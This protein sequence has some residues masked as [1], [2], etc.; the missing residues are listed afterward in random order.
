MRTLGDKGLWPQNVKQLYTLMLSRC[1]SASNHGLPILNW[2]ARACPEKVKAGAA[3]SD[4]ELEDWKDPDEHEHGKA[5]LQKAD[6]TLYTVMSLMTNPDSEGGRAK[7]LGVDTGTIAIGEG[8]K[9]LEKYYDLFKQDATSMENADDL[10]DQIA[11]FQSHK[12]ESAQ[13]L[14][15]RFNA[16][17]TKLELKSSTMKFPDEFLLSR[18]VRALPTTG[19]RDY[20]DVLDRHHRGTY[21]TLAKLQKAVVDE[22]VVLLKK[23]HFKSGNGSVAAAASA[24]D[25]NL[26][27]A[28]TK[29]AKRKAKKARKRAK[30][31]AAAGE[32]SSTM[33]DT[34][35][36]AS[37]CATDT[38]AHPSKGTGTGS[39]VPHPDTSKTCYS[40]GE[41]GHIAPRCP[42]NGAAARNTPEKVWCSYHYK[43]GYHL[44]AD[45][46]LNPAS[47]KG[48]G[49]GKGKGAKGKHGYGRGGYGGYPAAYYSHF[50]TYGKG[51]GDKGKYNSH[52]AFA[53]VHQ[54]Y[55]P[56][57]NAP[58]NGDDSL[59][60][61]EQSSAEWNY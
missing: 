11:H 49:K 57:S 40:C 59:Y 55:D 46:S 38:K 23:A 9:L 6:E 52:S 17:T 22:E 25:A 8:F 53:A 56:W 36:S 3:M 28:S 31:L 29:A 20:T 1:S 60:E 61:L 39:S 14:V 37:S 33:T 42:L 19:I 32:S 15:A 43:Y 21:S 51:K 12:D 10:S 47:P 48:K 30:A 7:D 13:V 41:V 54:P 26:A 4:D 27:P 18:F 34:A 16:L 2:M 58:T 5:A 45:C 24:T 44:E 35:A 50:H